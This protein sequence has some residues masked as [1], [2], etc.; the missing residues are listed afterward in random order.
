MRNKYG[1]AWQVRRGVST[2]AAG[3]PQP[4]RRRRARVAQAQQDAP[5]QPAGEGNNMVGGTGTPNPS[6]QA[7]KTLVSCR[8][9]SRA[10]GP[11]ATLVS[12][13]G[14]GQTRLRGFPQPWY[15]TGCPL[16]Q[17]FAH[18][19]GESLKRDLLC[20]RQLTRVLTACGVRGVLFRVCQPC[21][22]PARLGASCSGCANSA[23]CLWGWNGSIVGL[24]LK[25]WQRF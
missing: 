22:L 6:P 25:S 17:R 13:R 14:H 4:A 23:F 15:A 19:G 8:G 2:D 20:P 10:W 12:C 18:A 16:L 3:R 11:A 9:H 24:V 7:V 1:S 5:N 21:L